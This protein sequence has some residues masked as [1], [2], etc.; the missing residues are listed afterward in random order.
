VT[1]KDSQ[2]CVS[3]QPFSSRARVRRGRTATYAVW[4]W[5]THG[6]TK[7]V[8]VTAAVRQVKGAAAPRFSVCP[9]ATGATCTLG[10]L[11]QGQADELQVRVAVR[12]DAKPGDHVTLVAKA[13]AKDAISFSAS[14][15]VRIVS[16]PKPAPSTTSPA[17]STSPLPPLF[18]FPAPAVPDPLSTGTDPSG[19]FPT[20]SPQATAGPAA[21]SSAA[22]HKNARRIR[23][24][25]VSD[26]LPLNM[27]LIGGQLAGLVVLAAAIAIAITRLSLRPQRPEDSK[28]PPGKE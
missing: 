2:L 7:A 8:T 26:T 14:G 6:S 18:T 11:P 5:S 20:V 24:T 17:P 28:D 3:V 27:R 23:A 16:P 9:A 22:S 12:K 25:A 19:L 15:S 13:K 1:P 21:R 10:N 4:V